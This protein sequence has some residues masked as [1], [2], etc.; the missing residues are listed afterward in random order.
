MSAKKCICGNNAIE[1]VH[2]LAH[3]SSV[4]FSSV[5]LCEQ[6]YRDKNLY[7]E[8]HGPRIILDNPELQR[9]VCGEF[10][11]NTVLWFCTDC[12]RG[13]VSSLG[14]SKV[15]EY[16]QLIYSEAPL[17]AE[18]MSEWSSYFIPEYANKNEKILGG[19]SFLALMWGVPIEQMVTQ[20]VVDDSL[21]C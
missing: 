3:D 12:V 16:G 11:E 8:N 5:F 17:D 2:I 7:C 4:V 10:E 20:T 6:C 13:V 18:F 14:D 1:T 21:I 9:I 15:Q 19:C